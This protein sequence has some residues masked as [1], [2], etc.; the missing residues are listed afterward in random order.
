MTPVASG[1]STQKSRKIFF[2]GIHKSFTTQ[3]APSL[4]SPVPHREECLP[5]LE[6]VDERLWPKGEPTSTPMTGTRHTDLLSLNLPALTAAPSRAPLTDAGRLR[7]RYLALSD[8]RLRFAISRLPRTA[9]VVMR[10]KN[11]RNKEMGQVAPFV[12]P[13][14][15]A[16]AR[17]VTPPPM[18]API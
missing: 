14:S 9:I 16:A 2:N 17:G 11:I 1:D 4:P 15:A 3:P 8:D 13:A 7:R 18:A 5:S 12:Q 6:C 10:L